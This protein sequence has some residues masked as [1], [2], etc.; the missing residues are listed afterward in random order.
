MQFRFNSLQ[1]KEEKMKEKEK[2]T[3]EIM[4]NADVS[5]V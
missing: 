1:G 5:W 3:I 2:D 4:N